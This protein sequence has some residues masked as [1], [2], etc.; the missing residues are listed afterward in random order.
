M[1]GPIMEQEINFLEKPNDIVTIGNYKLKLVI[2]V[3]MLIFQIPQQQK[4]NWAKQY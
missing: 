3:N 2:M 4:K 1:M